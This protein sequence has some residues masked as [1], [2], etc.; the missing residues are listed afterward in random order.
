M[1][2]FVNP[3]YATPAQIEARRRLAAQLMQPS[4]VKHWTQGAGDIVRALVGG[5]IGAEA[6]EQERAGAAQ[7]GKKL[8]EATASKDPAKIM[9]LMSDP[10]AA[11]IQALLIGKL[12][13]WGPPTELGL[14][15]GITM[16]KPV[17]PYF[18]REPS[19]TPVTGGQPLPPAI[20]GPPGPGSVGDIVPGSR[21]VSGSPDSAFPTY[22][23]IDKAAQ[24]FGFGPVGPM[25]S[26]AQRF[27]T[28]QKRQE[29]AAGL[30]GVQEQTAKAQTEQSQT[31][32]Q[33]IGSE[34]KAIKD[35]LAKEQFYSPLTGSAAIPLSRIPGRP[36]FNFANR[37]E[38]LK[39]KLAI[40]YE[41]SLRARNPGARLMPDQV[42]QYKQQLGLDISD[43]AHLKQKL[44]EYERQYSGGTGYEPLPT[45]R[46]Q[47]AFPAQAGEGG[48][49]KL[50]KVIPFNASGQ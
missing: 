43:R 3:A 21:T 4:D 47:G 25:I 28:E 31:I 12:M 26:E 10:R 18:S 35:E 2:E 16:R 32:R 36:Q 6:G 8:L 39:N 40:L 46:P 37:I 20:P 34:I 22:P 5:H 23:A 15:G 11:P 33:S 50:I 27:V 14:P 13:E 49:A 45:P 24:G 44:D 29:A 41:D 17:E 38:G 1:A 42:E 48:G 30:A 9:E 7:F 19:V